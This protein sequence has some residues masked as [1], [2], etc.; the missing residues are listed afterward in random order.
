MTPPNR[1]RRL[2]MAAGA[3]ALVA[4][5]V[6]LGLSALR[7]NI[8][9][10][11]LP[12]ELVASAETGQR[13]RLGGFVVEGSVRYGD[14]AQVR[15][16]VTDSEAVVPVVYDGALPDL[17][18]EGKEVV[19]EGFVAEGPLVEAHQV[20]AKHDEAYTPPE[21]QSVNYATE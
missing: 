9:Y 20:L 2:I 13:V 18:G 4:A 14:G 16:D 17:F 11:K 19:A 8:S 1:N 10:F 7:D 15:F 12:S 3:L 5:A 6:A 21:L